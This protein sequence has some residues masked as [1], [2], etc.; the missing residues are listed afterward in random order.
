MSVPHVRTQPRRGPEG[1]PARAGASAPVTIAIETGRLS[2]TAWIDGNHAHVQPGRADRA[3]AATIYTDARTFAALQ[4]GTQSGIDGFLRGRLTVRGNLALALRLETML[5]PADGAGGFLKS[6]FKRAFGVDTFYLEAGSGPPV[7]LL[8]GLGA[9]NA[10]MLPTLWELARDHRVIAPDLPGF[11]DSGKPIRRYDFEFFSAWLVAF[12]DQLGVR[13]AT[14]IGNSMGGRIAVET[15]LVAP[16]RVDRLVLLAPSSAFL[17]HRQF[18]PLVRLL[19]PELAHFPLLITHRRVMDAI[20]GMFAHPERLPDAW[21]AAAA[22]EFLRV[23]GTARGRVAFFSA[24]RQIYLDEPH[25]QRGFWDRLPNLKRPALF[26][27]GERDRLVPVGFARH[28]TAALPGSRS[29][30]LRDCGH[31]PQYEMP[32]VTHRLIREFLGRP[33]SVGATP[34]QAKAAQPE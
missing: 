23:F 4:N 8:H 32:V 3:P 25:G 28:V 17:R 15:G 34:V 14:V 16:P 13:R 31:V 5:D 18:V 9:T 29:V 26:I 12:M 30:V 33:A 20:H 22:D 19:R 7:I 24:M 2:W 6:G 1:A 10:S 27:W 21:C 11:G